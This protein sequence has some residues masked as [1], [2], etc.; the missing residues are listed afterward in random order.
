MTNDKAVFALVGLA[1]VALALA[2]FNDFIH[3]SRQQS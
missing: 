2:P 3:S 1:I